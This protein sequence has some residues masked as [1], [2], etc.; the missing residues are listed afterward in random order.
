MVVLAVAIF[1]V[2][3]PLIATERIHRVAVAVGGVAALAVVVTD[4]GG[5]TT[6]VAARAHVE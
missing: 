5:Y 3:C 2:T 6:A 4:R 1:L